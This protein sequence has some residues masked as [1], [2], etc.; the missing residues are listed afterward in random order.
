M[1]TFDNLIQAAW[2]WQVDQRRGPPR[3]GG[4]R[5]LIYKVPVKVT[6]FERWQRRYDR[7]YKP[8]KY[9]SLTVSERVL[10]DGLDRLDIQEE[11]SKKKKKK[12]G[13]VVQMS[14]RHV[15]RQPVSL[16]TCGTCHSRKSIADKIIETES[17]L[18]FSVSGSYIV[19]SGSLSYWD[20]WI[21]QIHVL[22]DT[23]LCP[24]LWGSGWRMQTDIVEV[25]NLCYYGFHCFS[26]KTCPTFLCQALKLSDAALVGYELKFPW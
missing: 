17:R 6:S 3:S 18:P 12:P 1:K 19:Y 5:A 9:I 23:V 7:R 2:V 4:S 25:N 16:I 11:Q 10:G 15:E 22:S 21:E 24:V 8:S 13:E 14:D 20:T 26:C